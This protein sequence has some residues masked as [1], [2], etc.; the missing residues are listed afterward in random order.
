[1]DE[2]RSCSTELTPS[3]TDVLS[4][5]VSVPL[6]NGCIHAVPSPSTVLPAVCVESTERK[7]EG[8]IVWSEKDIVLPM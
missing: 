6:C 2:G 7:Q 4:D 5:P 8:V 3:K 1:M